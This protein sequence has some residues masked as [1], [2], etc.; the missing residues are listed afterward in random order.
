MI[1]V[2]SKEVTFSS[3]DAVKIILSDGEE[4]DDDDD[5][6]DDDNEDDEETIVDDHKRPFLSNGFTGRNQVNGQISTGSSIGLS[7]IGRI[8]I[9]K[10]KKN[11]R[12][13][14]PYRWLCYLVFVVIIS[15]LIYFVYS[16]KT[17]IFQE[18]KQFT[19]LYQGKSC[20]SL[21][22]DIL[23]NSTLPLLTITS[24]LQLVDINQDG[25]LDIIAAFG[26]GNLPR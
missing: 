1:K 26:T 13:H 17:F 10:P 9:L 3:K 4:E 21:N 6:Q 11:R 16:E 24:S 20:S 22:S 7:S 8:K 23:W 2:K 19:T 14:Q 12:N 18:L 15:L 5:K 25:N